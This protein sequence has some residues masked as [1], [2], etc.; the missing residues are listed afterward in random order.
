MCERCCWGEQNTFGGDV[1]A[2]NEKMCDD[3]WSCTGQL[4]VCKWSVDK[5]SDLVWWGGL[6]VQ[7]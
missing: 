7:N 2:G 3:G 1:D 4:R 5:G 6:V